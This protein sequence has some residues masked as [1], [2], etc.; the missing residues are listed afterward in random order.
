MNLFFSIVDSLFVGSL[1]FF[2][3]LKNTSH[4]DLIDSYDTEEHM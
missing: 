1:G 2:T 3:G 4:P